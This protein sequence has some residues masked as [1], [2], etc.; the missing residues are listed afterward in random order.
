MQALEF[1]FRIK[2]YKMMEKKFYCIFIFLLT[3]L[4]SGCIEDTEFS[5]ELRGGGKP[6]FNE[7]AKFIAKTASSI[8]FSAEILKENGYKITERGFV[9]STSQNPTLENGTVIPDVVTG[10]GLYKHK[11]EGLSGNTNYHIRPYAINSQGTQ[12]G[13]PELVV[14]TNPGLGVVTTRTEKSV[15]AALATVGGRIE[16]AGEGEI[17][18][19]GVYYSQTKAFLTKES[20]VSA[21]VTD[22]YDC[23]LENLLPSN[24]YYYK[25]FVE[26]TFGIFEGAIDSVFTKNG[27]PQIGRIE[28]KNAGYNEFTLSSIAMNTEDTTVQIIDRGFC[29]SKNQPNLTI[30]NDTI[31]AGA[32][33]GAFEAVVRNLEV[34]TQYYVRAYARSQFGI[35]YSEVDS[36]RTITDLPTVRTE[37]YANVQNRRVD[38]ACTVTDRGKSD[39]ISAGICWSSTNATPTK[40]DNEL[41]LLLGIGNRYSGQ[42]TGLKG[43]TRYYIRAYAT[44]SYGTNYGEVIHFDTP[45]PFTTGLAPFIGN[46]LFQKSNTYFSIGD[47]LYILGGDKGPNYSDE[48]YVYSISNDRWKP[49]KPLSSG[50]AKGQT[51]VAYGMGAFVFGGMSEDGVAKNNLMYYEVSTNEWSLRPSGVEAVHSPVSF[52]FGNSVYI[53]GGQNGSTVKNTVWTFDVGSNV[54]TRKPD[55]PVSQYG[56]VA[57]VLNGVA[58]AGLGKGSNGVCNGRFYMMASGGNTWTQGQF[59]PLFVGGILGGVACGESIYVIDEVYNIFE[60]TPN[61]LN[62]W[63]TKSKLPAAY[64]YFNCIFEK[65]GKIYIGLGLPGFTNSNSLIVYDPVWDN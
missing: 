11:L 51:G 23:R 19:R 27:L 9:Y 43:G 39:V 33:N 31:H 35:I 61:N 55:F 22:V 44:N 15:H 53:V 60:Y 26:N 20:A 4:L 36:A 37:N 48:L 38:L 56:G 25:A 3:A 8:E 45:P 46:E 57:A 50:P 34:E 54:W 10:I 17:L 59:Y 13:S 1:S 47:S 42:L 52:A 49:L 7:G 29:W 40:A 14:I 2:I 12:Y 28:S 5:Q 21:D 32:G 24:T 62:P 6:V 16:D 18:Y 63:T 65:N 64:H 30:A 58:Y 41:P